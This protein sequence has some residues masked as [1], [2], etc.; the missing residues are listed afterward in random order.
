MLSEP[1]NGSDAGA[2]STVAKYIKYNN[3]TSTKDINN[4][5]IDNNGDK[6]INNKEYYVLNGTKAWI[7]NAHEAEYGVVF[8]QIDKNLKHKGITCFIVNM[9]D[10]KVSLGKKENKLGIR[11]SSTS[12]VSFDNVIVPIENILGGIGNGF[13]IAMHTLDGGRIGIAGQAIGIAQASLD[14]A[15][16]YALERQSFGKPISNLYA[17]QEK[18]AQ[19]SVRIDA[20]RLLNL[21]AAMLKDAKLPYTKD[22][23]QAKLFA[24]ETA[25]FC[26]HQAIQVLGG[27]GFV[28]DMPA[29]RYYRDARITEIYEGTSEVQHI[30]I[31]NA[32]FKEY[33]NNNSN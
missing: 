14:C 24:S 2:A 20:A 8:A 31:A 27:M 23:A 5:S 18:I 6:L 3:S 33:S 11:G 32:V 21:K 22:A 9:K 10:K 16:K 26:S 12:T 13:K 30:V 7:T 17:I 15:T 4:D 28:S 19:M 25:T 29:E 1:G